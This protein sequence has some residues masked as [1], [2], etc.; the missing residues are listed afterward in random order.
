M[1]LREWMQPTTKPTREIGFHAIAKET[2]DAKAVSK[3]KSH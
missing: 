1:R 3:R 2:A